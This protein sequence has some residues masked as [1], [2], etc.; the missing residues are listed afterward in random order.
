MIKLIVLDRDG[1]INKDSAE[2]IKSP[3]EW[4]ALPKSLEAITKL[5]R[6]GYKVVVATNQSGIA[7][8]YFTLDTLRAIHKKMTT[9]LIKVGGSLDG[10]FVCPHLNQDYCD[11]RKPKP[12]LLL[13]AAMRFNINPTEMLIIGDSM[14]DIFAARNCGAL[15][16]L[17]NTSNKTAILAAK[18]SNI[19]I[20]SSLMNAV[21]F[22]CNKN[23]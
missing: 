19:L 5:K 7:R 10:I 15:S 14:S 17:V 1:T 13:K 21:D 12:G 20:C 16:I 9:E 4:R 3:K 22:I 18:R 23:I 8:G 11:C 2:Y 6:Y